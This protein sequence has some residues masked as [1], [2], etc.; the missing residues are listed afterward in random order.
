MRSRIVVI[1][2]RLLVPVVNAAADQAGAARAEGS[3]GPFG[4]AMVT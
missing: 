1:R 4:P 3:I 2:A